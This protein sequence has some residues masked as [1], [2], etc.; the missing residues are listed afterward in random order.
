MPTASDS[1]ALCSATNSS[2]AAEAAIDTNR[3]Q[4]SKEMARI[5]PPNPLRQA[6]NIARCRQRATA[7]SDSTMMPQQEL[8]EAAKAAASD[9]AATQTAAVSINMNR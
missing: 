4:V 3:L 2:F 1:T 7:A 6:D 5:A 9:S 8:V